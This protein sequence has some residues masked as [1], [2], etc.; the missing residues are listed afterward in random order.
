MSQ[1]TIE[2]PIHDLFPSTLSAAFSSSAYQSASVI[3][4]ESKLEE[5]VQGT[6]QRSRSGHYSL[7]TALEMLDKAW[8]AQKALWHLRQV[9]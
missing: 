5:F 1:P 6:L 3:D 8:K 2:T 7:E 9:N 4:L